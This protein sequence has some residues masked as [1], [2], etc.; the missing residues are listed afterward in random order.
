MF[1]DRCSTTPSKRAVAFLDE[2]TTPA[3][4]WYPDENQRGSAIRSVFQEHL[5]IRFHAEKVPNSNFT[6]DGN[7]AVIVMPAAIRESQ[8]ETGNTLNQAILYYTQF[9][10]QALSDHRHFY[11]FYTRFPCILMVDMGMSTI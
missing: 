5:D 1:R 6:T 3:C 7:F 2:L 10:H 9:L 4:D 8:K 11:N